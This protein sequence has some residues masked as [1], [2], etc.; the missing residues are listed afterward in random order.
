[1]Q[2][3]S[4]LSR[5]RQSIQFLGVDIAHT[6][7]QRNNW[8]KTFS[9]L[10][11]RGLA[12]LLVFNRE[13]LHPSCVLRKWFCRQFFLGVGFSSS[14]CISII[15]PWY[16]SPAEPLLVVFLSNLPLLFLSLPV[17]R[18]TESWGVTYRPVMVVWANTE[19]IPEAVVTQEVSTTTEPT[20]IDST[21][22]SPKSI[23]FCN[24]NGV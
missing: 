7:R 3:A 15:T 11:C 6:F 18:R 4:Q 24:T 2:E 9:W 14:L 8:R 13:V 5:V 17:S 1:M 20:S 10:H 23:L 22:F 19:S 12:F 16:R 21:L